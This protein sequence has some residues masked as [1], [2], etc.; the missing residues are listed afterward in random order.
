MVASGGKLRA[1]ERKET[2][3]KVKNPTWENWTWIK[4]VSTSGWLGNQFMFYS[5]VELNS[6]LEN[7]FNFNSRP[8]GL[9]STT[10][11]RF[12]DGDNEF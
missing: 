7:R 1:R 9:D 3:L 12:G 2:A 10:S 8:C 4:I 5:D 11:R 6:S